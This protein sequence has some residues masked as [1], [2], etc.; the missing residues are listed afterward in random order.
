MKELTDRSADS[1]R[2]N[3]RLYARCD[4]PA[5]GIALPVGKHNL[6]LYNPRSKKE[7]FLDVVVV[8][9]EVKYYRVTW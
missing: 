3:R 2:E 6:R 4:P 5:K 9:K 7:Q 1:R 8:A